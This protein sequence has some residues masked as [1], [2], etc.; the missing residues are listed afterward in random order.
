MEIDAPGLT[1]RAP[2]EILAW[3]TKRIIKKL[4]AITSLPEAKKPLV[5]KLSNLVSM[6][7][8]FL[9]LSISI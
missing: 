6:I 8:L 1:K 9:K 2:L 5:L 4:T 7:S 3:G